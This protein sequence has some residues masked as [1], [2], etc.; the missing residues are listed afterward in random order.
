MA[1]VMTDVAETNL[2]KDPNHHEYS[3]EEYEKAR[4]V[5]LPVFVAK[6]DCVAHADVCREHHIMAYPTLRLF[7]D[8]Q[9]WKGGDYHGHRTVLEMIHYLQQVEEEHKKDFG[10]LAEKK[11]KD[12]HDGKLKNGK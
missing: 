8:G 3:N 12:A 1:E 11:L 9:P 10:D 6:V 7:V 5:E 2:Q 4:D